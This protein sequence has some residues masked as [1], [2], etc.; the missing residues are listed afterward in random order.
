[1]NNDRTFEHE[2]G[3]LLAAALKAR[4]F[5]QPLPKGMGERSVVESSRQGRRTLAGLRETSRFMQMARSWATAN[6]KVALRQK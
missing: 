6:L 4:E 3:R 2:E 5:R 1:M